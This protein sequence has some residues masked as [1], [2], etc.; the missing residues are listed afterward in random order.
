M[1]MGQQENRGNHGKTVVMGTKLAVTAGMGTVYLTN[2]T[3]A[4]NRR[5]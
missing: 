2:M 5:K 3:T 4:L 1:G